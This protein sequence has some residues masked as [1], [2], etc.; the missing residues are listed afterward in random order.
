ME[1]ARESGTYVVETPSAGTRINGK[2]SAFRDIVVSLY[3]NK[4]TTGGGGMYNRLNTRVAPASCQP[5]QT[6]LQTI[7]DEA[8]ITE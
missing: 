1:I 6:D 8:S 7:H 2:L 5:G 3:G 4:I